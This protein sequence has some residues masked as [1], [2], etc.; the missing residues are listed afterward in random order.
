MSFTIANAERN[1]LSKP[2]KENNYTI[3]NYSVNLNNKNDSHSIIAK[4]ALGSKQI[5]DVG[6]GVGYIGRAIKKEH[7][8]TIDGIDIDKSALEIAKKHY[9]HTSL[10]KIG[11]ST[12]KVFLEFLK[13]KK[14]YDCIICGDIIE[15][16]A[17]PGYIIS[18]LAKKLTKNGKILVSIPNIAHI[19]VIANLID[20][21]FNYGET[22][23]LDNTHLRFWTESSFYDFIKNINNRYQTTLEPK[24]IGKTIVEHPILDTRYFREI[25]GDEIFTFQNIFE[26]KNKKNPVI[27]HPHKKNNYHDIIVAIDVRN[28]VANLE[29]QLAAKDQLLHNIENSLSWKITKPLRKVKSLFHRQ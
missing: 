22:G 13:D 2:E 4:H 10:M 18:I 15:H 7:P 27:P 1:T 5:L 9:D 6:C 23:I 16:L 17:D 3:D 20:E 11:D 21:R 19:D 29:S 24:L 12:D 26:L 8:C 28:K 25:C 14:L